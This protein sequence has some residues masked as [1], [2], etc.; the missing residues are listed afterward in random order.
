MLPEQAVEG[1]D[2]R[3]DLHGRFGADGIL[4]ADRDPVQFSMHCIEWLQYAA[5]APSLQQRQQAETG[6]CD[7]EKRQIEPFAGRFQGGNVFRHTDPQAMPLL[8]IAGMPDEYD[9]VPFQRRFFKDF[10]AGLRMTH[11]QLPIPEGTGTEVPAVVCLDGIVV[12]GTDLCVDTCETG[13]IEHRC[14][15]LPVDC[16]EQGFRI[17]LQPGFQQVG[18]GMVQNQM[19][20][21]PQTGSQHGH[22]CCC[23]APQLAMQRFHV[24][25][26]GNTYPW[27]RRV[28]IRSWPIFLRSRR[29]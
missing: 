19:S 16:G 27:P 8:A 3:R 29:I 24:R 11:R 13:M 6:Q 18:E 26:P 15:V 1:S 7:D 5:D 2:E 28:R 12:A 22:H 9:F 23:T 25:S 10:V 14:T 21:Q 4:S 17:M 20:D